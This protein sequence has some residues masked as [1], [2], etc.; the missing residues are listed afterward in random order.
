MN[1]IAPGMTAQRHYLRKN[2]GLR[3]FAVIWRK[4]TS[5]R[6][7]PPTNALKLEG[8][9]RN[10]TRKTS[11]TGKKI[12][13]QEH[14]RNLLAPVF[15]FR[16]PGSPKPVSGVQPFHRSQMLVAPCLMKKPH[17]GNVSLWMRRQATSLRPIFASVGINII[18]SSK[19]VSCPS[20]D[21]SRFDL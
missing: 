12:Q 19:V 14:F 20:D 10:L 9:R 5:S 3:S 7:P 2:R 1:S 21:T 15:Q 11:L 16:V 17:D 18:H 8:E 6:L 13:G 4:M